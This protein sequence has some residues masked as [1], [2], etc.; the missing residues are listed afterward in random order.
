M[1]VGYTG[2][3]VA[4]IIKSV[5]NRTAEEAGFSASALMSYLKENELILIRGRNLTRGK[6]IRRVLTECVALRI[7][8]MDA[9]DFI[10]DD[11]PFGPGE[12]EQQRF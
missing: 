6:R 3:K 10:P 2:N 8:D 5:F 11:L 1:G 7:N 12:V 9:D 4:F